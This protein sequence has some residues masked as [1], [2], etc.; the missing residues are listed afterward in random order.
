MASAPAPDDRTPEPAEELRALA[1]AL[2]RAAVARDIKRLRGG[3]TTP[4]DS[5][6]R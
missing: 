1:R 6:P 3:L 4:A 5:Q 2:A